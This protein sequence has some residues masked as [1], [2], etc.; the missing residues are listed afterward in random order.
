MADQSIL[1]SGAGISGPSAEML[2]GAPG[3]SATAAWAGTV[4]AN[5][6]GMTEGLLGDPVGATEPL[7]ASI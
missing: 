3:A 5:S 6:A 1:I 4:F 2:V 7:S